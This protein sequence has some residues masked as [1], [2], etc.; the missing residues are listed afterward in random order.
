V[1]KLFVITLYDTSGNS[2]RRELPLASATND[3]KHLATII[4]PIIDALQFC[5]ELREIQIEATQTSQ[6]YHSQQSFN[7]SSQ[8][9]SNDHS[10]AYQEL[11]NTFSVRLGKDR[12]SYANLTNSFIPE[13]AFAYHSAL[14]ET[15]E[16]AHHHLQ[17]APVTYG[18]LER[19]PV[20]FSH[21][22]PITTLAMLPDK[23]PSRISWRNKKLAIISGVGPERIAPEWWRGDVQ[24]DIF[25]E[26]DY[27]TVQDSSGRWLWVYRD[28]TTQSWFVH[29]VWT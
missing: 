11:L 12:I 15:N 13:R 10:R 14:E 7:A 4:Q 1:A 21:P 23:P 26:R 25:S 9:D 6:A 17:E 22:E 28:N 8:S 16:Q 2:H 19:P 27:F 29:G 20:L 18:S 3:I 5:G 24:R